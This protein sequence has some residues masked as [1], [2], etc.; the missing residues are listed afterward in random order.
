MPA[1]AI[2]QTTPPDPLDLGTVDGLRL[3]LILPVTTTSGKTYYF[4][5]ASGDGMPSV[6]ADLIQ[7]SPLSTLLNN[8]DAPTE[9]QLDGHDGRDDERSAIVDSHTLVLPTFAEYSALYVDQGSNAPTGWRTSA[10]YLTSTAGPTSE[11]ITGFGFAGLNGLEGILSQ[12]SRGNV[13]FQVL[14]PPTFG[15]ATITDQIYTAG[16]T[17]PTLTLPLASGNTGAFSYTLTPTA[18]IPAG[19]SFNP[20][21]RTLSGTPTTTT[22][23]TA[24]LTYTVTDSAPTPNTASLT[25]TATVSV[26]SITLTPNSLTLTEGA[27]ATYTAVLDSQPTAAVTVTI[28]GDG[29]VTPAPT[30]LTFTTGN[31]N[32]AQSVIVTDTGDTDA[33]QDVATLRH[34]AAGGDYEGTSA[35]LVVTVT[36][37]TPGLLLTSALLTSA[38]LTLDEDATATYS[39]ILNTEPTATVTVTIAGNNDDVTP[40]PATLTFT[41]GSTGNWNT[42]QTVTITAAEDDDAVDDVATLTHTASG[43]DYGSVT[44]DL[45]VTVTDN[46]T[47]DLTLTP[48]S[49]TVDEGTTALYTAV[50]DTEPSDTVTVTIA[51]D[52]DVTPD[53]TTLTFTTATWNTPQTVTITAAEDDDAVDDVATLTHTASGGDYGSVTADLAVTVTDN[54]TPALTLTPTTPTLTEG[55]T[56]TYSVALS[57]LPSADVVVA[58]ASDNPDVTP[59]PTP[60]TFTIAN[61]EHSRRAVT[62]TAAE[63]DDAVQDDVATLTHTIASSDTDYDGL[64][65]A[66]DTSIRPYRHGDRYRPRRPDAVARTSLTLGEGTAAAYTVVLNTEPTADGDRDHRQR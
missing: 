11:T 57:T 35:N 30:T 9:T 59:A 45:A 39:A 19:L 3:N 10:D 52:G 58:I 33:V 1:N 60:L 12:N 22:A 37:T 46:D 14:S 36:D 38:S 41:A 49:L 26:L 44:A 40:D 51:G 42:P 31:W 13:A 47:A 64:L 8:G 25:F 17:I 15:T 63:D 20:T 28:A 65:T 18:S 7:L 62:V 2:A 6:S 54:D 29:D 55:A 43:G 24:T 4:L 21:T 48:A 34:T 50:L 32:T 66:D 27:T 16:T 56:T 23:T 61:W 5:D 53:P